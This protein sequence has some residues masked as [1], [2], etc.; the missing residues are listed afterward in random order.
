MALTRIYD[1]IYL[2]AQVCFLDEL[3]KITD[4]RG[5]AFTR[6][7]SPGSHNFTNKYLSNLSW[8]EGLC[9]LS[10]MNPN[11]LLVRRVP[12]RKCRKIKQQLSCLPDC[13]LVGCSFISLHFLWGIL[14][15]SPV[16]TIFLLTS[17][18]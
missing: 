14:H 15:T 2:F 1:S 12:N 11:T 10:H 5:K 9:L 4:T 16:H 8:T 3:G 13:A 18:F 17:A 7:I 6:P